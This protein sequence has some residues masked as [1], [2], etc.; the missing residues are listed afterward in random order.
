MAKKVILGTDIARDAF[1]V[2][3]NENFTELYNKDT[4]LEEQINDLDA[5]VVAHKAENTSEIVVL[6]RDVSVTG[7]QTTTLN[8]DKI[9]KSIFAF[10]VVQL[11]KKQSAGQAIQGSQNCLYSIG[12]NGNFTNGGVGIAI[13][14]TSGNRTFGSIQNI[15]KGSFD[16]NWTH[17]GTGGTGTVQIRFL[18]LYHG[19]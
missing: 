10:S 17:T 3:V 12:D 14:D 18:I 6:S 1:K 16:I 7:I 15:K 19:E 5:E 13:A 4:S 9:P 8:N 11:T 2:K